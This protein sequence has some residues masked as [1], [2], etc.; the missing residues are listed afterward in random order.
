MLKHKAWNC[1]NVEHLEEMLRYW[2]PQ[3]GLSDWN[4]CLS[5]EAQVDLKEDSLATAHWVLSR[6]QSWVEISHSESRPADARIEDTEMLLVHELLH[7]G[8]S[9]WHDASEDFLKTDGVTYEVCCEQPIDQLAETLVLM[10]R[11]TG[12][13]FSFEDNSC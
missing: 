11:K 2:A 13:K 5:I 1:D 4:V 9:A 10:R 12:F 7:V 3:L 6:R 8:F